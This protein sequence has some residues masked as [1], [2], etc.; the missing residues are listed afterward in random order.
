MHLCPNC[1]KI[2]WDDRLRRAAAHSKAG[3]KY[4]AYCPYCTHVDRTRVLLPHAANHMCE[5]CAKLRNECE[6]CGES[7]LELNAQASLDTFE[8][9]FDSF[10]TLVKVYGLSAARGLLMDRTPQGGSFPPEQC[11]GETESVHVETLVDLSLELVDS[12][13]A[14]QH[15]YYRRKRPIW[16]LVWGQI[17]F[18]VRPPRCET[19]HPPPRSSPAMVRAIHCGHWTAGHE[20]AWCLPCAVEHRTCSVCEA[21]TE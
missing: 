19:C 11:L 20:A 3:G 14:Q 15:Y 2:D 7:T 6:A 10:V 9:L 12:Q 4:K 17:G 13:S 21:S 8:S 18:T 5:R 16:S 1:Q